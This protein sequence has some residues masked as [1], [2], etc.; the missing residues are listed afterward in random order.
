VGVPVEREEL[1]DRV[2]GGKI[3]PKFWRNQTHK[4]GER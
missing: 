3:C 4:N 2:G 1:W